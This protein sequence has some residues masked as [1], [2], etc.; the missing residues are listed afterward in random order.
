MTSPLSQRAGKHSGNHLRDYVCCKDLI[1]KDPGTEHGS[2]VGEVQ[3]IAEHEQKSIE[4]Q[5]PLTG[6]FSHTLKAKSAC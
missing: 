6:I 2:K 5:L 1:A 4:R 3:P